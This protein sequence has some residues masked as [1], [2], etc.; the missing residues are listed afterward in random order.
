MPWF[1]PFCD[2]S[3]PSSLSPSFFSISYLEL[4]PCTAKNLTNALFSE[5]AKRRKTEAAFFNT[6]VSEN[7]S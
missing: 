6:S 2:L 1:Y 3:S 4:A 7:E 5:V